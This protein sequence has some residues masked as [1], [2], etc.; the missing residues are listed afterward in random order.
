MRS[1]DPRRWSVTPCGKARRRRHATSKHPDVVILHQLGRTIKVHCALDPAR[2]L[3][4]RLSRVEA[5][6][7]ARHADHRGEMPPRRAADHSDVVGVD[8]AAP[9]S[10]EARAR[11]S[12]SRADFGATSVSLFALST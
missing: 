6:L 12:C 11:R 4:I 1:L 5:V 9:H 7:R 8:P 10:C 3:A 2:E